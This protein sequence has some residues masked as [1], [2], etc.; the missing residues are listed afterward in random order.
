MEN[1]TTK[2]EKV[3]DRIKK[4]LAM[5]TSSNPHEA[6]N[7][8]A[9]AAALMAEYELEEADL[10]VESGE[11]NVDPVEAAMWDGFS[12]QRTS[13]WRGYLIV[14][15]LKAFGCHGYWNPVYDNVTR[16]RITSFR[17]I[18]RKTNV[19]TSNYMYLYLEEELLSLCDKAWGD[20]PA[21]Q[22]CMVH[23]KRWRNSFLV[24]AALEVQRRL[25]EQWRQTND[26][27]KQS[28]EKAMVLVRQ[29]Q[30]EVDAFYAKVKSELNLK[31]KS[32]SNTRVNHDAYSQGKEAGSRVSLGGSRGNI[33]AA[34]RQIA[35]K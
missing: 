10:R 32:T 3:M 31:A 35:G 4:L 22:A 14:G 21:S 1:N 16:K 8:A 12:S 28:N 11:A 6:A 27:Y 24:G 2:I 26:Y 25:F 29:D 20:L 5:A 9:K 18:G 13:T 19:Q 23:G 30:S 34:P 33:G 15:I 7:A 17:V